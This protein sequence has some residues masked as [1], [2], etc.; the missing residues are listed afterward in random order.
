MADPPK[1]KR[2]WYQFRLR[3]LMIGVTSLAA[4]CCYVG[5]QAEIVRERQEMLLRINFD[6][7]DAT[8]MPSLPGMKLTPIV[9]HKG[10]LMSVQRPAIPIIRRWLGDS[11]VVFLE[12]DLG[13][14]QDEIARANALFP[15]AIKSEHGDYH[16]IGFS[17]IRY[18][19]SF[20]SEPRGRL[21]ESQGG[22]S[23]CK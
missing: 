9:E 14:G 18:D 12:F 6:G 5:R 17:P 7:G 8:L 4:V 19:F 22:E 23:T 3:T 11:E 20:D 10:K 15:E 13:M 16:L 2:R 21:D 1:R